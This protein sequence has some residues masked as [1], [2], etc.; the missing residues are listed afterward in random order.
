MSLSLW[1]SF[2]Q[3]EFVSLALINPHI[4]SEV[5]FTGDSTVYSAKLLQKAIDL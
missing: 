3:S 5:F 2:H 4:H 1:K